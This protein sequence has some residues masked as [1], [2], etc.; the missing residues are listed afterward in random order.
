MT[1][2]VNVAK[3]FLSHCDEKQIDELRAYVK[4]NSVIRPDGV[5]GVYLDVRRANR[6]R[7][8]RYDG[9]PLSKYKCVPKDALSIATKVIESFRLTMLIEY[10]VRFDVDSI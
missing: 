6:T 4:R 10:N 7:I 1:T 5:G 9:T 3:E 2:A 8:V